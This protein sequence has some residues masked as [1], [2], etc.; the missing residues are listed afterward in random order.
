MKRSANRQNSPNKTD[1]TGP[2]ETVLTIN[3][4]KIYTT[5]TAEL[6]DHVC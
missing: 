2:D 3:R 5:L 4:V 6:I 1:K